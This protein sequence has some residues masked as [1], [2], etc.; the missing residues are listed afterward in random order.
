MRHRA[1]APAIVASLLF[2]AAPAAAQE[3]PPWLELEDGTT[4]PQFDF[5]EAIE[6]TVYV[7]TGLDTD[8]DGANDRIRI[9]LSRPG[10]EEVPPGISSLRGVQ[11][12]PECPVLL[13]SSATIGTCRPAGRACRSP[14]RVIRCS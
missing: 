8:R 7:E 14:A 11:R 2:F 3:P 4:Q 12:L 1:A 5:S 13:C 9:R 10:G 6:E